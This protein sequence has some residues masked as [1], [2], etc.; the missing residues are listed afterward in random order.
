MQN[1]QKATAILSLSLSQAF[2]TS[3]LTEGLHLRPDVKQHR[4]TERL[5]TTLN[6]KPL[7]P[8][9]LSRALKSARGFSTVCGPGVSRE[10]AH[11]KVS[12]RSEGLRV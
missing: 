5:S 4:N 6:P 1:F 12:P 2:G 10:S 11:F 9:D 8:S 3:S 7:K